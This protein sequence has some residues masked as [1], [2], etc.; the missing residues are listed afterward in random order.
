MTAA[1]LHVVS[2]RERIDS[3]DA[4]VAVA[5]LLRALG[6]DPT[7]EHLRDTRAASRRR[8]PSCSRRR[9]SR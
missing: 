5:A 2:D 1:S 9:R 3:D 7:S 8:T 6:Q 4:E